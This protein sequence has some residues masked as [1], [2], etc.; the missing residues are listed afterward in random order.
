[1][2]KLFLAIWMCPLCYYIYTKMPKERNE[3]S[4]GLVWFNFRT[5]LLYLSNWVYHSLCS[6]FQVWLLVPCNTWLLHMVSSWSRYPLSE[7]NQNLI[8]L[9][10]NLTLPQC[11]MALNPENRFNMI[12]NMHINKMQNINF[13]NVLFLE[14]D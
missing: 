11:W 9:M 12:I 7:L 10:Y 8:S 2:R 6:P 14:L 13:R 3:E 4:L 1:M 5:I